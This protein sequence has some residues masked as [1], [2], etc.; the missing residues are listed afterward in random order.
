V[1][2]YVK[3]F[4]GTLFAEGAEDD[5]GEGRHALSSVF[6]SGHRVIAAVHESSESRDAG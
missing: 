6:H 2:F 4:D 1:L 5:L 3:T